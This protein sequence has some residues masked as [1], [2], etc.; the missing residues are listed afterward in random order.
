MYVKVGGGVAYQPDC[1]SLYDR[2]PEELRVE[3]Y[4]D[5]AAELILNEGEGIVNRFSC[6]KVGDAFEITAE[7]HSTVD[8]RYTVVVYAKDEEYRADLSV[9]AGTIGRQI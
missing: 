4:A 6:R 1:T 7:N 3:L 9:K 2:A 5:D 8:R